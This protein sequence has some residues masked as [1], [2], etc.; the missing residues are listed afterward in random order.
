MLNNLSMTYSPCLQRKSQVCLEQHQVEALEGLPCQFRAHSTLLFWGSP[1]TLN[2]DRNFR[3][4][5]G[6]SLFLPE[7]CL[8][9]EMTV[10]EG[11]G[12]IAVSQ[13][14]VDLGSLLL[15]DGFRLCVPQ[16]LHNAWSRE[17][18]RFLF[19]VHMYGHFTYLCVCAVHAC[20]ARGGQK[21]APD[22]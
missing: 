2:I 9:R 15:R 5:P 12:H 20:S 10:R 7:M 21:R 4:N 8:P 6:Q 19:C 14:G 17:V 22:L 3:T 18:H 13:S 1:R 16:F 11:S